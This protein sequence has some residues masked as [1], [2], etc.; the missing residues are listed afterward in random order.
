MNSNDS[1]EQIDFSYLLTSDYNDGLNV[2]NKLTQSQ[3]EKVF[4]R[5]PNIRKRFESYF[6]G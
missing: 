3:L 4:Q 1:F 2:L 5:Y 6:S